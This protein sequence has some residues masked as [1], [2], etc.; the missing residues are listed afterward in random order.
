VFIVPNGIDTDRLQAQGHGRAIRE[1]LGIPK[2]AL[3]V[4]TVA[5][6][7]EVKRQDVLLRGFARLRMRMPETHLVVVGDGPLM[8]Q[9]QGQAR[10]LGIERLVH[11]TGYQAEPERFY[12]VMDVFALTSRS[13]GMPQT[14]L[15]AAAAGVPVVASAVGGIPEVVEDGQTGLLFRPGEDCALA[16]ALCRM[17][18]DRNLARQVAAAARQQVDA[19]FHVRRMAADYHRHFQA[20]LAAC[21]G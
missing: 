9:L 11:F 19:R 15:E 17:L 6:L 10:D 4:G 2:S 13:E 18:Q 3:V 8:G 21:G 16:N 12:E 5:R 14:I 1:A 20:L 7:T